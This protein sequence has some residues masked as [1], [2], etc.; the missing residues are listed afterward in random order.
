MSYAHMTHNPER[1]PEGEEHAPQVA[2]TQQR[3]PKAPESYWKLPWYKKIIFGP[4]ALVTTI[5][6]N[7]G[8]IGRTASFATHPGT[9][10]AVTGGVLLGAGANNGWFENTTI[11]DS[12]PVIGGTNPL[13]AAGNGINTGLS[14]VAPAANWVG[15]GIAAGAEYAGTVIPQ[16]ARGFAQWYQGSNVTPEA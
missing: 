8:L 10:A 5:T 11:A 6:G 12:I 7:N 14:A 4:Q 9:L 1:P 16:G 3:A 2:P 13:L 15:S